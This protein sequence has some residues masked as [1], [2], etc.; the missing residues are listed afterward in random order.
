[1]LRKLHLND[2]QSLLAIEQA[3]H[4]VP[5][6]EETFKTC[7]Q[8]GHTGWVME[9]DREIIGFIIISMRI[10]EC[11]I[12]NICIAQDYQRQG[13]GEQLLKQVLDQ[14]KSARA[15]IVYLEVRKSNEQAIALYRKLHFQQIAERKNYYPTVAGNEDALIFAK[16]VQDNMN[17]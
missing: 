10:D 6:N 15:T 17:L 7:F 5:W 16:M 14:A 1:M 13:Y 12:L 3:V 4:V 9:L 8:A 2:L 11:H